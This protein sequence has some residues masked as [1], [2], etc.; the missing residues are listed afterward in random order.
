M[1]DLYNQL[2]G[3]TPNQNQNPMIQQFI[4]F[5]NNF[6]GDPKQMVQNLLNSGKMSQTQF[7]ALAQQATQ[8]QKMFNL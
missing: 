4:N 8:F 2:I 1:N 3:S 5:R 6:N 7:N